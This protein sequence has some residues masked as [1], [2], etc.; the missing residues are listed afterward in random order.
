M[1]VEEA[2]KEKKG[3]QERKKVRGTGRKPGVLEGEVNISGH[4]RRTGGKVHL[5]RSHHS[6]GSEQTSIK[7]KY[8]KL[9]YEAIPQTLLAKKRDCLVLKKRKK[10]R[11]E[12]KK[13]KHSY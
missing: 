11:R 3:V 8:K 5:S 4:Q 12:K 1:A 7:G 13:D 6:Y 10:K 2:A 9:V